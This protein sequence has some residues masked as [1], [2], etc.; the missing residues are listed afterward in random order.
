M[1]AQHKK[2]NC[3]H[4]FAIASPTDTEKRWHAVYTLECQKCEFRLTLCAH[5]KKDK[6][7]SLLRLRDKHDL[8]FE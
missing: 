4:H 6:E 1:S 2:V 8:S 7:A 5:S 3:T